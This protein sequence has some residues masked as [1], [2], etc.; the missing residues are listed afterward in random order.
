MVIVV[1]NLKYLKPNFMNRINVFFLLIFAIILSCS[2]NDDKRN[3]Q[4]GFS[5]NGSD[6][7]TNYAYHRAGSY[8]F[9]FS[10]V[11]RNL[12]SYN[13]V[14]G[15]FDIGSSGD[16][17]EPRTYSTN[18]SW[19]HGVVEFDKNIIKEDGEFVSLG[20]NLAFTCCAE[21]NSNNFQSGSATINS[22]EYNSEGRVT[23]INIDYS[24]NWDG[25]EVNGNYNGDVHHEP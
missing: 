3:I 18:N 21:S 7:S 4:N 13:E 22:I 24:F 20:D 16:I 12:N 1:Y 6:Y 2:D 14:R 17:L 23:Y 25:K 8:V 9:I 10:S 15:R 19:I 11:D 5:V